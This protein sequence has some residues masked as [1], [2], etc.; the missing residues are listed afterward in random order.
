MTPNPALRVRRLY[1][2]ERHGYFISPK[3][4]ET[5]RA[6]KAEPTYG[7]ITPASVAR[8]LD[9]L[10]LHE[11]DVLYD[12]GSGVGK[13]V[14]QAAMTAACRRVVGVEL[15]RSRHEIACEALEDAREEGW[16]RAR[17]VQLVCR[18]FM[19]VDISDATVIY[20]CTTS[21]SDEFMAMMVRRLSRQC[22][23]G[24]LFLSTQE[25][26]ETTWLQ[27]IR[28]LRLDMSWRRRGWVHAYELVRVHGSQRGG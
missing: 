1:R 21:F 15:A 4:E 10:D 17:D 5:V 2:G 25:L 20:S 26:E 27:P 28:T 12:L 19:K 7:E 23:L 16:I 11:D 8:L 18:N 24:T 9:W 22:R 13:V 3:E 6:T 14:L